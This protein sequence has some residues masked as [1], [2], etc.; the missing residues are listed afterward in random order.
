MNSSCGSLT[1]ASKWSEGFCFL[2]VHTHSEATKS[3]LIQIAVH[4]TKI[5]LLCSHSK[6]ACPFLTQGLGWTFSQRQ[7]IYFTSRSWLLWVQT[8]WNVLLTEGVRKCIQLFQTLVKVMKSPTTPGWGKHIESVWWKNVRFCRWQMWP[9]SME[10][11]WR[12]QREEARVMTCRAVREGSQELCAMCLM[13]CERC[14]RKQTSR[15]HVTKIPL[16]SFGFSMLCL[17]EFR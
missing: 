5:A 17:S 7:I 9:N 14:L 15:S 1:N 13:S 10:T 8:M 6:F 2:T 16:V 4:I 12:L 11:E 3:A